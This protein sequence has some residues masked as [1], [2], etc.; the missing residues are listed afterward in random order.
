M[1]VFVTS[2]FS[3]WHQFNHHLYV[4][5]IDRSGSRVALKVSYLPSFLMSMGDLSAA[6]VADKIDRFVGYGRCV[7]LDVS[8]VK[9]TRYIG[10]YETDDELFQVRLSSPKNWSKKKIQ[11]YKD[12]FPNNQLFHTDRSLSEM[13]MF[14]TGVSPFGWV[15]VRNARRVG[16][17]SRSFGYSEYFTD[18]ACI[19]VI[20]NSNRPEVRCLL[21]DILDEGSHVLIQTAVFT[22]GQE[23]IVLGSD[24]KVVSRRFPPRGVGT[25][26]WHAARSVLG[27]EIQR[28]G[29]EIFIYCSDNPLVK[30]FL[31]HDTGGQ[32]PNWTV[33]RDRG[34]TTFR[35]QLLTGR[36]SIDLVDVFRKSTHNLV[37]HTLE[38]V[39]R[40]KILFPSG[41]SVPVDVPERIWNMFTFLRYNS[42]LL[43]Y[44][45]QANFSYCS[46]TDACSRGQQHGVYS[47]L[48]REM[49]V[50][51]F[52][53]NSDKKD[54]DPILITK[55]RFDSD[56]PYADDEPPVQSSGGGKLSRTIDRSLLSGGKL[57]RAE[58]NLHS[59]PVCTL[60]FSSMYP[61]TM[62]SC[63]PLDTSLYAQMSKEEKAV[64]RQ[65]NVEGMC[66]SR[67][68][69]DRK[70]LNDEKYD[71]LYVPL[72][73]TIALPL[74]L[75]IKTEGKITP[76][77]NLLAPLLRRI[78]D[79]RL[80]VKREMKG[81]A[82]KRDRDVLNAKQLACKIFQNSVYGFLGAR[83]PYAI[84]PCPP[85]MGAVC[86]IGRHMI[87]FANDRARRA[88]ATVVYG[89]TDSIMVTFPRVP[90][91]TAQQE[92]SLIYKQAHALATDITERLPYPHKFIFEAMKCPFLLCGPKMYAAIQ[93][94]P[95]HNGFMLQPEIIFKGL[96][97]NTRN[98][99]QWVQS[100]GKYIV[101]C[102]LQMRA[103][104]IP[105][106]LTSKLQQLADNRV[107][108]EELKLSCQIKHPDE[109]K[110]ESLIQK[111][112]IEKLQRR[113]GQP[114]RPG[115]RLEYMVVLG[116]AKQPLY[117]RGEPIQYVIQHRLK[118]DL[119]YYLDKQLMKGLS[120]VMDF[121]PPDIAEQIHK[122][123][124]KFAGTI[125][126]ICS[127]SRDI[128]SM[129]QS[130]KK[131]RY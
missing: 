51:G 76:S 71:I 45:E 23:D 100:I 46:L 84:L 58:R 60:D 32:V 95:C 107:P 33:F 126:R 85:L 20:E 31:L 6:D 86:A 90:N 21:F 131:Q 54:V 99:A 79:R 94:E 104:L 108:L 18:T 73:K 55:D 68:V 128:R 11:A 89:D 103:S 121:I 1:Q 124:S 129:F 12:L 16:G 102:I 40:H 97:I 88:G 9:R 36:S 24:T 101:T 61:T 39:A 4:L 62:M 38:S 92:L 96:Q 67:L 72:T 34:P 3:R 119:S 50:A 65:Q 112:T 98:K 93:Y 130:V 15:E 27:D 74:V 114:V 48:R 82:T 59:T 7:V 2:V 81:A 13:F 53:L 77:P 64:H 125:Q 118:P 63:K 91:L 57:Q 29:I 44:Q 75:G 110:S 83:K 19:S 47:K 14:E 115:S 43:S 30:P 80:S 52:Y 106:F 35:G 113:T 117:D 122:I 78:V 70:Y 111:K 120:P 116:P 26:S 66:M 8:H 87:T 127:G 37:A 56:F 49:E 41:V 5:G 105:G 69:F 10:F 22:T 28:N 123:R 17:K 25:D 109:Y 42:V